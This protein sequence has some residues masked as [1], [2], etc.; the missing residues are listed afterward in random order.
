[1]EDTV[2]FLSETLGMHA[3]FAPLVRLEGWG[4]DLDGG[5]MGIALLTKLPHQIHDVFFYESDP[6]IRTITQSTSLEDLHTLFPRAVLVGDCISEES[7]RSVAV[8]TTHFTYTPDGMPDEFQRKA[9]NALLGHL[10]SYNDLVI[11]GDFNIPRPNVLYDILAQHFTDNIPK[12]IV[13][14]LDPELHRKK[15]LERMVDYFWTKGDYRAKNVH[16]VSGVSDH[17]AVVGEVGWE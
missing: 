5:V 17:C 4:A 12:E 1:M 13:S 11:T 14:S 3:S 10:Q 16:L 8:A 6:R 9:L 15:G 7:E 2:S